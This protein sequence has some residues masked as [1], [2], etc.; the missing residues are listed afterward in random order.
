MSSLVFVRNF[1][2]KTY[3][4]AY[5]EGGW[6]ENV[7][8]TF[9]KTHHSTINTLNAKL[10]PICHMLALLGTYHILHVSRIRVKETNLLIL[11]GNLKKFNLRILPYALEFLYF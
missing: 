3:W 2:L 7:V 4:F 11:L 6:E 10:N 9:H 5:K 1:I 8:H